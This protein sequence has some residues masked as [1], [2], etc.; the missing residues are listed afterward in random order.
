MPSIRILS[1]NNI[2]LKLLYSG[3]GDPAVLGDTYRILAIL[4]IVGGVLIVTH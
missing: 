1:N 4:A 3:S 2:F